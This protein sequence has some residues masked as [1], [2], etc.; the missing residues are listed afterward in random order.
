MSLDDIW[1]VILVMYDR[2]TRVVTTSDKNSNAMTVKSVVRMID[3]VCMKKGEV[4]YH[5]F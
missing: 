4:Y 5:T 1:L 3:I 2:P